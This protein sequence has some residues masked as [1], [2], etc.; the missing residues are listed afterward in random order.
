MTINPR[1]QVL[2]AL[3]INASLGITTI[4]LAELADDI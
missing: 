3:A 1:T 4:V 2:G